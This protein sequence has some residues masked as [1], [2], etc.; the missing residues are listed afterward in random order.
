MTNIYI[1]QKSRKAMRIIEF[2]VLKL[3]LHHI[4]LFLDFF[5]GV[6]DSLLLES[7]GSRAV[8]IAVELEL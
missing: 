1:N 7:F 6:S 2:E 8:T 5:N 4:N 3:L